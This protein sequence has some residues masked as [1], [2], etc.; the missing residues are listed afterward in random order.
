[1]CFQYTVSDQEQNPQSKSLFQ[2]LS[3]ANMTLQQS[4]LDKSSENLQNVQSF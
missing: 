3:E 1:M 4:Q 2:T